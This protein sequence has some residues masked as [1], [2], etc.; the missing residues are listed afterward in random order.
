MVLLSCSGTGGGIYAKLANGVAKYNCAQ[1]SPTHNSSRVTAPRQSGPHRQSW[2]APLRRTRHRCTAIAQL[3]P[4]LLVCQ[5]G[6]PEPLQRNPSIPLRSLRRHRIQLG[7]RRYVTTP[8]RNRPRPM[9]SLGFRPPHILVPLISSGLKFLP[10][11]SSTELPLSRLRARLPR[12]CSRS[13]L[14]AVPGS[15]SAAIRISCRA[16]HS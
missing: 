11:T 5:C 14:L 15:A 16:R 3:A 2:T 1:V 13:P 10:W 8:C 7:S 6:L 9:H 4:P 12:K